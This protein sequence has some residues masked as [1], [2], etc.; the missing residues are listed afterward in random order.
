MDKQG[1]AN[2]PEYGS[3]FG[4]TFL[5]KGRGHMPIFWWGLILILVFSIGL[6]LTPVSGR[7]SA[8]F[9]IPP[10][11]GFLL[12]DTLLS[13]EGLP[14]FFDALRHLA[15]PAIAMGTIPLAVISR[16]TRSSMLEVIGEDYMRTARAKGLKKTRIIYLHALRRVR[17]V[18]RR[19]GVLYCQCPV[20]P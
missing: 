19:S 17:A 18:R 6:G 14:A 15:L 2:H 11:T 16:M 1:L 9:D 5:R 10:V 8:L 20:P 4:S 12:I 3:K 7:I 13:E